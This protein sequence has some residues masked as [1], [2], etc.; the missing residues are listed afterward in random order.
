MSFPRYERYKDS[1]I[2]WLGE[3]P[4]HWKI[5]AIKRLSAVRRGASPRPIDDPKYF[6]EAGAYAWVRISDVSESGGTLKQTEQRL[7][8]LGASLSVK[9]K[10]GS[11]FVSIAGSVGKPC[12]SEINACIHDGFVYFPHLSATEAR[13]LYR[14]FE[15][16]TCYSGLGKM[17]TQLN[18]NTDTIGGIAI[19]LPPSSELLNI[20]SILDHET[21]K[22][23][24]LIQ[25]QQRLIELLKE[26]RQAVISHAV[27]K[28]LDPIGPM[29]DS[30]N[31]W[32]GIVPCHWK[33]ARLKH[34][35]T[36]VVDCLHSTPT[37]DGELLYPAI[38]TADVERGRLLL[39]QA[40][41]VSADVFQERT[42]RLE[43][44]EGDVLYSREGERFG[45][46]ALVPS[47][48]RLCLGQRMMMFRCATLGTARYLMWLLN[49]AALYEQVQQR[50]AGPTAP[51]VNISEIVNFQVPIPPLCEQG[52]IADHIESATKRLDDLS[53]RAERA[54]ALL[55]ERRA[56]LISAAV[57]GKIDVRN[58][59]ARES[60]DELYQTA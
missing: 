21:A 37:Y 47:N 51:H 3:V 10:S 42:Q 6:D 13:Y 16:A 12:I 58:Y 11:L 4:E 8:E 19:A 20:I 59:T 48:T 22:I 41:L 36:H 24:A 18:L 32:L 14:V 23:D 49:S 34:L 15:A 17:G 60:N 2:E 46:A 28:G 31:R 30:G 56:A 38:R 25:A 1:G 55:Q 54:I 29:K 53:S 45:M 9:L 40:R 44:R 35:T 26:K 52:R 57:T 5:S 27:T 33:M 7:S 43:P 39:D 50:F